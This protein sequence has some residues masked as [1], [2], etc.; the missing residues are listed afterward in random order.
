MKGLALA[1]A[2]Y[3]T[4]GRVAL[5]ENVP[6]LVPRMAVGLAGEGS[7]CFGFDDEWSR[8]HDWGPAFCIWLE[9]AD[10][11]AHG[12]RVQAVYDS[13]PGEIEGFPA[14]ENGAWSGGRVGCLCAPDWY[15]RYTGLPEGPETLA[16]WRRVPEAFLA[17]AT[18]GEIFDDPSGRFTAVRE[19][20]SRFYPEDVRIK[21]LVA[22]AAVMAQ[23]GQYNYPRSMKRG[24]TVA[25]RLALAE[26]TKAGISMVY[27][28]NRRYAPFYKWMHRGLKGLPKLPRAYEQFRLLGEA[29]PG[30]E[31]EERIE[32]ICLTVAA[33][34]KRQG[35]TDR[36]EPFLQAH[37][38][39]MMKRIKDPALRQTHIMEE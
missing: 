10:Y 39:E 25:A 23:A 3:E 13:L 26:F 2:Y 30:A 38:L 15:R 18:N 19:R 24:E 8:D 31:T 7:E 4:V 21:K 5:Q 14:R 22:R 29:R 16:Q 11:R 37:C 35:L 36:T 1:R 6:A 32:G 12:A 33:E 34:L 28:L 27:L 9:E 20:L 17:T